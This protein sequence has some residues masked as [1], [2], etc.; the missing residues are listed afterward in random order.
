M[1]GKGKQYRAYKLHVLPEKEVFP[2][3]I[4]RREKLLHKVR[5]VAFWEIR[6]VLNGIAG[7]R[8][9]RDTASGIIPP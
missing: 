3:Y 1:A 7:F 4:R 2:V 9:T 5:R 8:L 6:D